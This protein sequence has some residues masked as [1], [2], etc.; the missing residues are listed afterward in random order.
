MLTIFLHTPHQY[1]DITRETKVTP[2]KIAEA[3]NTPMIRD[4]MSIFFIYST[5][6]DAFL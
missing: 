6:E 2:R 5:L 3:N 1:A 4:L